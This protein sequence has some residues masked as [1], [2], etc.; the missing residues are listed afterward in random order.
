MVAAAAVQHGGR[1]RRGSGGLDTGGSGLPTRTPIRQWRAGNSGGLPS[2]TS[3]ARR[4]PPFLDGGRQCDDDSGG[5][6]VWTTGVQRA[7]HRRQ[8]PLF[9]DL[10]SGTA[11]VGSATA[12]DLD[13]SGVSPPPQHRS[14]GRLGRRCPAPIRCR[15]QRRAAGG[16]GSGD[17]LGFGVF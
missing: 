8:R 7:R 9:P 16:D 2:P 14:G 5:R 1:E 10:P 11:A 15:R 13:G 4:W 6:R 12:A 17:G 3:H